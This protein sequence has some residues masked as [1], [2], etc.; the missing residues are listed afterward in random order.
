[1]KVE[2]INNLASP[3]TAASL[4]DVMPN[5]VFIAVPPGLTTTCGGTPIAS[6]GPLSGTLSISGATIPARVGSVAG[7][8]FVEVSVFAASRGT[9]INQIPP[10]SL[11]ATQGGSPI[12]NDQLAE[13]TLTAVLQDVTGSLGIAGGLT[14]V[15]GGETVIRTIT[16]TNPNSVP[17]TGTSFTHNLATQGG[18]N[19]FATG[20]PTAN[21]C[22]GAA[23]TATTGSG[24]AAFGP[25]SIVAL[26]GGT[27]P[28]NGSCT[29]SFPVTTARNVT[30]PYNDTQTTHAIPAGAVTTLEGA[31]NLAAISQSVRTV[32]GIRVIKTFNGASTGTLDLNTATSATLTLQVETFNALPV[33]NFNLSDLMPAGLQATA[34]TRNTCGGTT[35]TGGGTNVTVSGATLLGITTPPLT[36]TQSRACA[37]DARIVPTSSV[38]G[39]YVNTIPGATADGFQF[40]SSTATLNVT[41]TAPPPNPLSVTKAFQLADIYPGDSQ[42]LTFTFRNTFD[43][44]IRNIA[45]TDNLVTNVTANGGLRIGGSG[46]VSQ[47]C[48]GTVSAVPG[49]SAIAISGVNLAI[50]ATCNVVVRVTMAANAPSDNR[51]IVNTVPRTQITFDLIGFPGQNPL[52]GASDDLI[53][54]TPL[55]LAKSYSPSTVAAGGVTRLRMQVTRLTR[56]AS[57]TS[58]IAFTDAFPANH[59]IANPAN[60]VNECGGTVTAA[61]ASSS[62]SLSGGAMGAPTSGT[63][64][65]CSVFVNVVAPGTNGSAANTVAA[66]ALTAIDSGQPAGLNGLA[67]Q[68]TSS[69]TLIRS[70]SQ[71]TVNKEFLPTTVK[72]GQASRVRITLSN[73]NTG[74][75]SLT[76]VGLTDSFATS[77]LQLTTNPNP[78]FTTTSAVP[79]SGGCFGGNYAFVNGPGGSITLSGGQIGAN[80]T[81][82]FEFN[83]T[84]LLGGNVQNRILAGDVR[85]DQ[86]TTNALGAV[87]TLTIERELNVSKGFRPEV[88]EAG[89]QT[90]LVI[91][92]V[93][94]TDLAFTGSSTQPTLID[95]MP[96]G[97]TL[98]AGTQATSCPGGV[99][100]TSGNS[101]ILNGGSFPPSSSCEL[102]VQVQ[103]INPGRFTNRIETGDLKTNEG[104]SNGATVFGD[105]TVVA[106]PTIAKSFSPTSI[107]NGGVSTV[108]FTLTNQNAAVLLPAGL[109]GAS[110]SDTFANMVIA[111]P[112]AVGGTC[113]N[114]SFSASA[115]GTLFSATGLRLAPAASC[116]VTINV[117]S[118][119]VGT[120][121]NQTT[122][123]TT[124]QTPTAGLPSNVA[125]LTV[126]AAA[127]VTIAKAF[128]ETVVFP[129]T[130]TR[131]V[132]T[133]T[134]PNI[135]P[136]TIGSPGF[137][138]IFPTTP[139]PMLVA[140][141]PGAFTTCGGSVEDLAGGSVT[142]GDTGIR[143]TGGTVPASATCF[144]AVNVS[145]AV[146][147]NYT[148]TTSDLTTSVGTS[149]GSSGS[150]TVS[151][152]LP[153]ASAVEPVRN[154]FVT[155]ANQFVNSVLGAGDTLAGLPATVGAT[156]NVVLT[157]N[158]ISAGLTVDPATG[159]IVVTGGTPPGT[160]TVNYTICQANSLLNCAPPR[161]ETVVVTTSS[162]LATTD[163]SVASPLSVPQRDLEQTPGNVLGPNDLLNGALAT[164]G[165][166]ASGNVDMTILSVVDGGGAASS[167]V[168][169]N[170]NTGIITVAGVAPA[171]TYTIT[172]RIC[173]ANNLTNCATAI[174]VV[175]V[176]LT[177][178]VAAAEAPRPVTAADVVQPAG[179]VLGAGDQ[180]AGLAATVG[181]GATGNVDLSVVS[182]TDGGGANAAA[183]ILVNT[184]SGA[185][186]V[187]AGTPN[188][189]YS[190]TYRICEELSRTNCATATETVIVS[191]NAI[192]AGPEAARPV[193]AADLAVTAG[194]VL[195][196]AND[197]VNGAPA[198]VGAGGNVTLSVVVGA[199]SDVELSVNLATGIITVAAGTLPGTYTVEY[200][201]CDVTLAAN[202]ATAI[203]TVVVA[204]T[205]IVAG[206]EAARPVSGSNDPRTAGPVQTA[207]NDRLGGA[208]AIPGPG[209]NVVLTKVVGPNTSTQLD[210][211][212]ATGIITVAGGTPA[213]S[214]TIEYRICEAANL[215]NCASAIET[216]VISF[217]SIT[218]GPEADRPLIGSDVAQGAGNVL[219]AAND[220]LAGVAAVPGPGGTVI[221]SV[222]AISPGLTLNT[223][224]GALTLAAGALPGTYTVTYAICEVGNTTNCAIATEKVVVTNTPISAAGI[225]FPAFDG[226]V[227]GTTPPVTAN[228]LLGGVAPIPGPGGTVVLIVL[229]PATDPN[230]VLNPATGIISVGPGAAPGT[231]PITYQICEVGNSANCATA[232]ETIIVA[233]IQAVAEVFP[234]FAADGGTTTSM[235]ASD[236]FS[237]G[238][239][240]LADVA[241]TVDAADVGVTLEPT[242]GLITL[243][244][245]QPAGSYSVTYTICSIVV[246]TLCSTAIETVTQAPI[247]LIKAEKT[248]AVPSGRPQAVEGDVIT[249]SFTVRNGSNVPVAGLVLND[250]MTT[251]NGV[252]VV[253]DTGPDFVSADAGSP[254]GALQIGE[255]ATYTGT[256]AVTRQIA[257]AGGLDNTVTANALT[258]VGFPGGQLSV[259]ADSA[260]SVDA[261]PPALPGALSVEKT[262]PR[263]VVLRGAI[264][265]YTI[266]VRNGD[267]LSPADATILDVLPPGFLYIEGSATLDGV[268]VAVTV[269]GR[270]IRWPT[271]TVPALGE[272]VANVSARVTTG[273]QAGEHVNAARVLDP[274]SGAVLAAEAT[275]T[276]RILPEPVFDCGDVI[277]KVF[278]DANRD[279]YQNQGETG[280]PAVRLAGVDGTIIT[281]DQF[282]R[283]HVPCAMLP[284]DRGSNFVLK[285]DTRTLPSGFRVT[286]ENPR[287][288]RLTPGK[289]TEINFGV[290]ITRVVRLD[291]NARAFV[292]GDNGTTLS[293]AL[294]VGIAQLLPQIADQA[295]NL[296]LAYHLPASATAADVKQARALM[297]QVDRHIQSEWRKVGQ[298]KLTIETTIVRAEP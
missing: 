193:A 128:D 76:G 222:Q 234:T 118:T 194:T 154:V 37:I 107:V 200:R 24:N 253:L 245:G 51:T 71:L 70:S 211:N 184:D 61:V 40:A 293:P 82:Y 114:L 151:N 143:L 242:T 288:V 4:S 298:V 93:N 55:T 231:Y 191:R 177:P 68:T 134:N 155:G 158:T 278:D 145:M 219:S 73:T 89:A 276:V 195:S 113:A 173:E 187:A 104:G 22:G 190:V 121:P 227:G 164:V 18:F 7:T 20:Q 45:L 214:Y 250:V 87:A 112:P 161:T 206:P 159:V 106:R 189:T 249:F 62:L 72:A 39:S 2:F 257:A 152:T 287:M 235:L 129:N 197:T 63:S 277:G 176:S 42:T 252:P 181:P 285:L 295:V 138:D 237:G 110:F 183:N 178:I 126:G 21:T 156:G 160:Y 169:V 281:T 27:I 36:G 19:L 127:P 57:S 186:T 9:F 294:V 132:L 115:G 136:V 209:G 157:I 226:A 124:I 167:T 238:S 297:R 258:A 86:G 290:A 16:L 97:I 66:G 139:G 14:T 130:P 25:S 99:A 240:T 98:I 92:V 60:V 275:A 31:T 215:R 185:I 180:L 94:A 80:T 204:D 91:Q 84:S 163:F 123:V 196:A 38:P 166:G 198:T 5:G 29:I 149:P 64:I 221:L 251:R 268:P 3:A 244:P 182:V 220:T 199:N 11:T 216:V 262:T 125:N 247:G 81:C 212:P 218:A 96:A 131:M 217:S 266:T 171:G 205:A 224:T 65:N 150:I 207:P 272:V 236:T 239:A 229:T 147:G 95:A 246:P 213:G 12:S 28:A 108:T 52:N 119:I 103:T 49:T 286:T 101:I 146:V 233:S 83:V 260:A 248:A 59:T 17:L 135:Y 35:G 33:S 179:N 192:L 241:I 30:L 10:N 270:V 284:A 273:A 283:F 47:T 188:G 23:T 263:G 6:N 117:T 100:S 202:C 77:N 13:A 75:A 15:Q 282:G 88:V 267:A 230:I 78:T 53:V 90:T 137:T 174:E 296:R 142:A 50:G 46:F 232:T 259:S 41:A 48:G 1:M 74:S 269:S 271:A 43:Q 102:T 289:M 85:S 175:R 67:T 172:Y 56:A 223:A 32:S 58:S 122:G 291:L 203:E 201:I 243:A 44:N 274:A 8:C 111:S 208:A 265:P 225:I 279:G 264:V 261:L 170:V 105:L 120:H 153:I 292:P 162:I 69:A 168:S 144:V 26:S 54:R 116:T 254:Q 256:I 141:A 109:S 280:V 140:A 34:I 79:N 165:A 133:L 210:L 148:N 228:D 255:T